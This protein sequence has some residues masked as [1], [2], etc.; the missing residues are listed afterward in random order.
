MTGTGPLADDGVYSVTFICGP[1]GAL[2]IVPTNRFITAV[3]SRAFGSVSAIRQVTF[4]AFA[5]TRP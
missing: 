1:S 4:G 2:P 5:G 3:P